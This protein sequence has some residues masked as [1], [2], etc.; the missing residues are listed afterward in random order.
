MAHSSWDL[1][2]EELIADVAA[3]LEGAVAPARLISRR[4]AHAVPHA[5]R[6]L[7]AKGA[8]PRGSLVPNLTAV[9]SLELSNVVAS[10][11][12][13][14]GD[15]L[16]DAIHG[17]T[18]EYMDKHGRDE[19]FYPF[20][21]DVSPLAALSSLKS[22][23]LIIGDS[24]TAR[25]GHRE[26]LSIHG[27]KTLSALTSLTIKDHHMAL[28][29]GGLG[30]LTMLETLRFPQCWYLRS[31]KTL[32][33]LPR[34]T[35][36]DLSGCNRAQLYELP[37]NIRSLVMNGSRDIGIDH[38]VNTVGASLTYLDMS[39]SQRYDSPSNPDLGR[40][41]SLETLII[42][43]RTFYGYELV[44]LAK[45]PRLRTLDAS[46]SDSRS[47]F[48]EP[49][50][51]LANLANLSSLTSLKLNFCRFVRLPQ[52]IDVLGRLHGLTS[53]EVEKVYYKREEPLREAIREGLREALP[54][55][56]TLLV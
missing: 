7:S 51:N 44:A 30:L 29:P 38:L 24:L 11:Y 32:H 22:L 31:L 10:D 2:P 25:Y 14:D 42:R 53:L 5:V 33:N 28:P 54:N 18:W 49:P 20:G 55:L 27:L 16:T 26:P 52:D 9:Q 35:A 41:T 23:A 21:L 17:N 15:F 37:P 46:H 45:L 13:Y 36:L 8:I 19:A 6:S 4:W 48:R 50:L 40:L 12:R 47:C 1:L 39:D 56:T 3:K 43:G 34:L